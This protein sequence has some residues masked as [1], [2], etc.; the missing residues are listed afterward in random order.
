M[1]KNN[2]GNVNRFDPNTNFTR[3]S[4]DS[5]FTPVFYKDFECIGSACENHCCHHWS[6]TV[7]RETFKKYK[8]HGDIK[9]RTI[10]EKKTKSCGQNGIDY[11]Q[12]KLEKNGNCPLLDEQNLCYL[13]KNYGEDWLPQ[14]CNLYPR[15]NKLID[16]ELYTSLSISCPEA[17]R[18]ILLDPGSMTID[19]VPVTA[20][21]PLPKYASKLMIKNPELQ[22]LFKKMAYNCILAENSDTIEGRLFNLGVLFRLASQRLGKGERIE[23]LLMTFDQVIASGDLNELLEK[24]EPVQRTQ[25][26]VLQQLLLENSLSVGNAVLS[27]YREQASEL[28]QQSGVLDLSGYYGKYCQAGYEKLVDTHG[29]AFL[30]LMLHWVYSKSFDLEDSELLFEQFAVFALKF[31]YIRTLCGMLNKPDNTKED[32][33]ALLVGITHCISRNADHDR[34]F[35]NIVHAGL[36]QQGMVKPEH[37]LGLIKV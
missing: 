9:V 11:R 25:E 7:D 8:K 18:K 30:N 36:A 4:F 13:H 37:I 1:N 17:A 5:L 6:V 32:S 26:Y 33:A 34:N 31:F 19:Q 15:E 20:K 23:Q 35:S 22:R 3:D 12:I 21:T 2:P 24:T 29:H 27:K 10:A 16:G 14:I 28:A